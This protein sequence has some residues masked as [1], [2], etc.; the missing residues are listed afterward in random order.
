MILHASRNIT[1]RCS[2]KTSH[3]TSQFMIRRWMTTKQLMTKV[4]QMDLFHSCR[5]P[6]QKAAIQGIFLN[7]N[8]TW[9]P[10][11]R[12]QVVRPSQS[13]KKFPRVHGYKVSMYSNER[14]KCSWWLQKLSHFSLIRVW[15]FT[16]GSMYFT[17]AT[18]LKND[19]HALNKGLL[20]TE[21]MIHYV[22]TLNFAHWLLT[23]ST[24]TVESKQMSLL[25]CPHTATRGLM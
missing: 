12:C 23:L 8:N 9:L 4:M 1:A 16:S 14:N 3:A 15:K 13:R 21:I 2:C 10:E 5:L 19:I 6:L 11:S 20:H 17:N 24:I 22:R 25:H 18:S 7:F